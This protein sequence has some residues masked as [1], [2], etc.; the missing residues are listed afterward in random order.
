M[1]TFT[2][3]STKETAFK[4]HFSPFPRLLIVLT[5]HRPAKFGL[6][7]NQLF[8]V[9]T[10]MLILFHL[11]ELSKCDKATNIRNFFHP[12]QIFHSMGTYMVFTHFRLKGSMKIDQ[13]QIRH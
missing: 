6:D 1:F 2:F 5:T 3:I 9:N 11:N 12:F 10:Y 4:L 7:V 8:V 13:A